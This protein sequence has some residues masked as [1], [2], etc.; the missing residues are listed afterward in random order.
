[1]DFLG[2]Q[3]SCLRTDGEP[4]SGALAQEIKSAR[5]EETQLEATPRS[6]SSSL[7]AVKHSNRS[8]E[9]QIRCTRIA[10]EKSADKAFGIEHNILVSLCCHSGW[11]ITRFHVQTDRA[12][13][14]SA[15]QRKTCSGELAEFGEQVY[16]KDLLTRNAKLDDRWIG[17][18]VRVGK[19]ERRDQHVTVSADGRSVELR[20]SMRQLPPS[21]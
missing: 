2:L 19:A 14:V 12:H 1:M 6:S 10:L 20:K 8:V 17:P 7:G 15:T 9:G 11:L 16:V 21:Q 3:K 4:A 13:A 18:V 5:T